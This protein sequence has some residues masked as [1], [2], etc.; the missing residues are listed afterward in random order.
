MIEQEARGYIL[1]RTNMKVRMFKI[2]IIILME[3]RRNIVQ[4]SK[5][6]EIEA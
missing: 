6:I 5:I 2:Y 3:N 1:H 4:L